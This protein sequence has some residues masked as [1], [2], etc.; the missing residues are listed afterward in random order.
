M[1]EFVEAVSPGVDRHK[2]DTWYPAPAADATADGDAAVDP[3]PHSGWKSFSDMFQTHHAGWVFG[4]LREKLAERIFEPLYATRE[5][6]CS[7]EGFT[8]HRPTQ[9]GRHPLAAKRGFVCGKPVTDGVGEHFD[10]GHTEVGLQYIQSGTCLLDQE[11]DD[12]CFTCWPGSHEH[13]QR[14]R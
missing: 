7:K 9:G 14:L 6:H 11:E 10:Q 4:E 1:W 8:F 2:P 5:L 12:G 13:H 3:W